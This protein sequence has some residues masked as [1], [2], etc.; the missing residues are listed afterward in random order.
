MPNDWSW[1]TS[2]TKKFGGKRHWLISDTH[3]IRE[4]LLEKIG[5]RAYKTATELYRELSDDYGVVH[6]RRF[7]R[8]LAW[9]LRHKKIRKV[10]I[11]A[12]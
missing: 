1:R 4:L 12:Y 2:A 8:A 5:A 7:W 6:E 10:A 3:V 11:G 9:L